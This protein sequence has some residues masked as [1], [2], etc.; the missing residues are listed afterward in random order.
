MER[1]NDAG[2]DSVGVGSGKVEIND[3]CRHILTC[4]NTFDISTFAS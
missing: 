3:T 1:V 2:G 4:I